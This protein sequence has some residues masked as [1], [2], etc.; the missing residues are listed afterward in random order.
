MLYIISNL[1]LENYYVVL[2]AVTAV[3]ITFILINSYGYLN[4]FNIDRPRPVDTTRLQEGLP[5]DVTITPEDF[6]RNPELAQIF[7]GVDVN[8]NLDLFLEGQEHVDH[9]ENQ[10]A[11]IDYN[12]LME[13]YEIIEAFFSNFF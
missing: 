4:D 9:L 13:L 1:E 3:G 12:T 7:E 10:F 8:Q 2:I 5:T 6:M 11:A